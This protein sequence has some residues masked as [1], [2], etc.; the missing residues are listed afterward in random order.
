MPQNAQVVDVR[1]RQW[2]QSRRLPSREETEQQAFLPHLVH[3]F[4]GA[5][6]AK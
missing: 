1:V 5:S 3:V 2:L 6:C 4:F